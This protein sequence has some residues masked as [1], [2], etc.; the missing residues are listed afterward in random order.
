MRRDI[1]VIIAE[2]TL[3]PENGRP[4]TPSMIERVLVNDV[5]LS[6]RTDDT[7]KQQVCYR[8]PTDYRR[9]R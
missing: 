8:I 4:Y 6:I 5:H 3:N 7:A 1:A 9:W 2:K